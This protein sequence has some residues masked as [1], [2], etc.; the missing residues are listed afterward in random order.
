MEALYKSAKLTLAYKKKFNGGHTSWSAAWE[1]CLWAR[2]GESEEMWRAMQKIPRNYAT[3]RLLS[4]HPP[5]VSIMMNGGGT[6]RTAF[7]EKKTSPDGKKASQTKEL[8]GM[9]TADKSPV[10]S[11]TAALSIESKRHICFLHLFHVDLSFSPLYT[12]Y[13]PLSNMHQL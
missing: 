9:V 8:S 12:V 11:T 4:L 10:S 6:S 5:T 2:L 3:P 13:L 1:A 7:T